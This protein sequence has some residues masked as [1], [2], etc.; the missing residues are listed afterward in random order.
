MPYQALATGPISFLDGNASQQEIPLSAI[1]FDA[2]GPNAT[3]WT[4]YSS[5]S[6]LVKALLAQL[7]AQG[8]LTPGTQTTPTP[9]LSIAAVE[10]GPTGNDIQ[11]TFSNVSTTAG[12]M[13]VLVVATQVYPGQTAATIGTALGT[14]ALVYVE[15]NNGQAPA[16][17]WPAVPLAGT[18]PV[19]AVPQAVNNADTAF[20][21]APT[22]AAE[23]ANITI[24]VVPDPSPAVTFTLTAIWQNSANGVTLATLSGSSNPF[25][26]V[27]TFT[28]PADGPL[29]APGTVTLQGGAAA[30]SSP[31]V[32][33]SANV[34]SS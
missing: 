24:S 12:T 7:V 20:V 11:V 33:A 26:L 14:T 32:A 16:E 17:V 6:N 22:V 21:L 15:S 2:N 13:S 5:N 4:N 25:A 27:V 19:Y 30:T 18:P 10:A 31:A 28:G 8:L 23:A 1:Y 9:A 34:L 3:S 29:P